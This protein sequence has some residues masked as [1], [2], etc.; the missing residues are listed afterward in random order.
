M[1]IEDMSNCRWLL[2]HTMGDNDSNKTHHESPGVGVGNS[3]VFPGERQC[4]NTFIIYQCTVTIMGEQSKT[5]C[6][7]GPIFYM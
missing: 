6:V 5:S 4:N 1:H 2:N 3:V 7:N